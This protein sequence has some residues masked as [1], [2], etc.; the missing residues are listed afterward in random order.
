M[1]WLSSLTLVKQL[2]KEKEKNSEFKP[3]LLHLKIDLELE[4][5]TA[6]LI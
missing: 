1:G 3:V 4:Y 5:K 2:V 6:Q